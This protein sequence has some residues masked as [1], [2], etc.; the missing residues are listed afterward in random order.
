MTTGGPEALRR[1]ALSVYAADGVPAACLLLQNRFDLDVN[2]LLFAAYRGA[3][4]GRLVSAANLDTVQNCVGAWHN[5]VV[6]PLRAVRGRLKTGPAPAPDPAT[7]ELRRKLQEL[8]I[9][10]EL[11][12]LTELGR[13]AL[14]VAAAPGNAVERAVAAMTAVLVRTGSYDAT[15]S[16]ARGALGAIGAAAARQS[17][18]G[19]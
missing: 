5:E 11:I 14:D 19:A 1:F 2:V 18:V 7:I 12:E 6:R 4:D 17:E 16:E 13:L 8:E 3:V 10:A 9:D 15:D